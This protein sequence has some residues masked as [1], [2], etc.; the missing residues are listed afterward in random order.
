MN[1]ELGG[2]GDLCPGARERRPPPTVGGTACL[3]HPEAPT[4]LAAWHSSA[5]SSGSARLCRRSSQGLA[6]H[7]AARGRV[8]LASWKAIVQSWK[9]E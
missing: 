1:C 3:C 2:K 4:V 5:E 7:G 6:G 9:D 8:G